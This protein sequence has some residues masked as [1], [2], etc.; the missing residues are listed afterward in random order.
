MDS[1]FS[2]RDIAEILSELESSLLDFDQ[3]SRRTI[4]S[5][6]GGVLVVDGLDIASDFFFDLA[7][8]RRMIS[9]A[10]CA[11]GKL[12]VPLTIG[13]VCTP[14]RCS[15]FGPAHQDHYTYTHFPDELAV[16]LW[17]PLDPV[18]EGVADI[19]FGTRVPD[20]LLPHQE[21][22]NNRRESELVNSVKT[23]F[24]AI[25]V[26]LG[27]CLVYHSFAVHRDGRNMSPGPRRSLRFSYRGS[28][29]RES[30]K[31]DRS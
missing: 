8:K 15:E 29:Y 7:R 27:S 21:S 10:E 14:S 20:S 18:A 16:T 5:D 31:T 19:E 2:Q 4:G 9:I 24:Q 17:V 23:D 11:L 28:P 30:L 6:E 25:Q 22:R 12:V 1:I 13:Y 26:P 3:N